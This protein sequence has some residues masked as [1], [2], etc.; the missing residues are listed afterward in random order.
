MK[1]KTTRREFMGHAVAATAGTFVLIE[2]A[3][4][5]FS[6][7]QDA[8]YKAGKV[9]NPSTVS[10]TVTYKGKVPK[11]IMKPITDSFDVAGKADRQWEGVNLGAASGVTDAVVMIKGIAE[12]KD[13][14]EEPLYSYAE[15]ATI[16]PRCEVLG[17]PAPVNMTVENKDPIM[18]SWVLMDG[19]RQIANVPHPNKD[20][21]QINI[22]KPGLYEMRCGPH[23][24]ERAFRIGASTPYYTMTSKDGKYEIKD[25]P[26]GTY[27]V[28]VWAEGMAKPKTVDI[29]VA[30]GTTSFNVEITD[31]DLTDELKKNA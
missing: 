5:E 19:K 13:F 6:N 4:P 24:W 17:V 23:P 21:K 12:G 29:T 30:A 14:K 3:H 27:K 2:I 8:K 18:H 16:L 10:G 15:H 26:A 7:A 9:N 25:V 31:A 11:P 1:N 28:V 22:D 20:K